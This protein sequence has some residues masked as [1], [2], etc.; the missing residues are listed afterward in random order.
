VTVFYEFAILHMHAS[1]PHIT[2]FLLLITL[3]LLGE[4]HKSW[5]SQFFHHLFT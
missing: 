1:R 4:E 5:R 3:I 2:T